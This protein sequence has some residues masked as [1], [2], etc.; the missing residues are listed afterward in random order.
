MPFAHISCLFHWILCVSAHSFRVCVLSL[1]LAR[2]FTDRAKT[3]PNTINGWDCELWP[4]R[5]AVLHEKR[6]TTNHFF[7]AL[8]LSPAHCVRQSLVATQWIAK[9][10][11]R[12]FERNSSWGEKENKPIERQHHFRFFSINTSSCICEYLI[13]FIIILSNGV[14]CLHANPDENRVD[15]RNTHLSIAERECNRAR[16]NKREIGECETATA[17]VTAAE[18]RAAKVPTIKTP[19]PPASLT[20]ANTAPAMVESNILMFY[21][22]IVSHSSHVDVCLSVVRFVLSITTKSNLFALHELV[23]SHSLLWYRRRTSA[24]HLCISIQCVPCAV[25]AYRRYHMLG[26]LCIILVHV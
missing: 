10:E 2:H 26:P 20:R 23:K 7:F 21:A 4:H 19:S 1:S 9:K 14:K 6:K 25:T 5:F 13:I 17:T 24:N 16:A 3:Q 18:K 15:K 11:L 8:S 22:V 12:Q